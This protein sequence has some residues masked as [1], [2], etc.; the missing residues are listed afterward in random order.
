MA[1]PS[2]GT[3]PADVPPRSRRAPAAVLGLLLCGACVSAPPPTAAARRLAENPRATVEGRVTDGDGNPVSGV[4][5]QAVPGGRDVLWAAPAPTD[6]EGR[7]RLA[8][9]A[10]A[11]YV[12]I[13]FE[14]SVAVVTPSPLDPA[15]VR[16]FL[17]PGEKKTGVELTLL[18]QER[19]RILK[20]GAPEGR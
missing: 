11:Q 7:F 15:A 2:G 20:A 19:E 1:H 9:D 3:I 16:V 8:L 10:P 6:A 18:R 12:F 4:R 17:Q 13:I 14:D 5:V